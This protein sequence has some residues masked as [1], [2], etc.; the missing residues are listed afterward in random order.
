[1][2]TPSKASALLRAVEL[3]SAGKAAEQSLM[4]LPENQ[5]RTLVITVAGMFSLL[6]VEAQRRGIWDDLKTKKAAK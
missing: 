3:Y 4:D 5:F 2:T 6:K 1:M